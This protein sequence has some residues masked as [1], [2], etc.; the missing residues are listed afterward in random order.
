MAL[1]KPRARPIP[2]GGKA[3]PASAPSEAGPAPTDQSSQAPAGGDGG[4]TL[5]GQGDAAE[6]LQ[7]D[8]DDEDLEAMQGK[9]KHVQKTVHC[10]AVNAAHAILASKPSSDADGNF[11]AKSSPRSSHDIIGKGTPV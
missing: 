5:Q 8:E 11:D 3:T 6:K 1:K 10:D 7:V 9:R 4:T 2:R